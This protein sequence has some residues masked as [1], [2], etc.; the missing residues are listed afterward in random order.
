MECLV[1]TQQT[2]GTGYTPGSYGNGLTQHTYPHL[3]G[4][5]TRAYLKAK[6]P[7]V[8]LALLLRAFLLQIRKYRND[9]V[10]MAKGAF[11]PWGI[12]DNSLFSDICQ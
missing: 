8:T 2:K 1:R 10:H 9:A 4:S 11:Y 5:D 12:V 6:R 7:D 3:C